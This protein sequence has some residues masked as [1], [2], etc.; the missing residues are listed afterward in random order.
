M[1][2][3]RITINRVS[4]VN[5]EFTISITNEEEFLSMFKNKTFNRNELSEL[6]HKQEKERYRKSKIDR[7]KFTLKGCYV[8]DHEKTYKSRVE[9]VGNNKFNSDPKGLRTKTQKSITRIFRNMFGFNSNN[10]KPSSTIQ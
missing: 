2:N 6:Y 4:V 7:Q 1:N 8:L 3:T 5:E 9:Q 10:V